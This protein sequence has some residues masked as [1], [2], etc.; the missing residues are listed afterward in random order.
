MYTPDDMLCFALHSSALA[1]H[2]AYAPLLQPFGLTYPQYLVLAALASTPDQT[3]G[4][5]GGVLRLE[6]N[7]LT[8][9]LKRMQQAGWVSRTR[10]GHD[11]RVVRL[12]LTTDGAEL[13]ARAGSASRAFDAKT[14]L[15]QID[16]SDLRDV[17][18]VLRDR[19][20]PAA[21]P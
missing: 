12:S 4:Q 9:L 18:N 5:L 1:V 19:L 13:A 3:V 20:K 10:D 17:L 21:K 6:S 11:E 7:T 14:G 2:S 15:A 8:P 16:I